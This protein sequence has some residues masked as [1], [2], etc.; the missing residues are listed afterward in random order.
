MENELKNA[1]VAI[2]SL[3]INSGNAK[4]MIRHVWKAV[5]LHEQQYNNIQRESTN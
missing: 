3:M 4:A 5:G 1:L 2:M